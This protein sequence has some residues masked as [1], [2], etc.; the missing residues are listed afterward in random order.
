MFRVEKLVINLIW[1]LK[2]ETHHEN[3]GRLLSGRGGLYHLDLVEE[4][5]AHVEEGIVIFAPEYFCYKG[6]ALPEH[7]GCYS[8]CI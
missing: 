3:L 1:G 6:S 8:E 4:L 2:V 5:V 7:G